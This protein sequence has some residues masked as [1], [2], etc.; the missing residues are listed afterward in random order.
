M[1]KKP[2]LYLESSVISYQTAKPSRDVIV[3]GHQ[4][5]THQWWE[6]ARPRFDLYISEVV[7]QEISLGDPDAA[8]ERLAA[9]RGV[10]LLAITDRERALARTYRAGL[11]LG[12]RGRLD[13]LH[14]ACAVNYELDFLLTWNCAHLANGM[15]IS[16]VQTINA[17]LRLR[18]PIILTPEGLLKFIGGA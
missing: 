12:R 1:A 18:T 13:L 5:I 14:L 11:D 15:V 4:Q 3:A 17:G 10:P 6:K 7:R 8:M 9:V 16:R 2:T